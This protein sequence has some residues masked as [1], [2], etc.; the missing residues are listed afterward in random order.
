M[1]DSNESNDFFSELRRLFVIELDV[2]IVGDDRRDWDPT[3]IDS[4]SLSREL[5]DFAKL[6]AAIMSPWKAL[7]V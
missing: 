1:D 2:E 5:D 7:D 6:E 4:M 3:E